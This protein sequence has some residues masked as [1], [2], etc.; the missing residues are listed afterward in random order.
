MPF[1]LEL[2]IQTSSIS[3]THILTMFLDSTYSQIQG[4]GIDVWVLFNMVN[5]IVLESLL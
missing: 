1:H 4:F 3:V 5:G 2:A